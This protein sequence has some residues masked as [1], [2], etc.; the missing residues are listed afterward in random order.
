ME[1]FVMTLILVMAG[2]VIWSFFRYKV[3]DNKNQEILN[4][5]LASK[6]KAASDIKKAG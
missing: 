6:R 2:V 3:T 1:I 4:K 5:Y